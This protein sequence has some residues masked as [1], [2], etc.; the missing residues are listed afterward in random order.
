MLLHADAV[1]LDVEAELLHVD[2]VVGVVSLPDRF[3]AVI[4]QTQQLLGLADPFVL[5]SPST[6]VALPFH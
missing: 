4:T 6:E 2:V 1:L 3:L 5:P